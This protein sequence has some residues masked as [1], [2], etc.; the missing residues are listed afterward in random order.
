MQRRVVFAALFLLASMGHTLLTAGECAPLP[1]WRLKPVRVTGAF[2]GRATWM[3]HSSAGGTMVRLLDAGGILVSTVQSDSR[4]RFSF[5]R[6]PN[7]PYRV[8]IS[9][10]GSF[11]DAIEINN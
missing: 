7:G 10:G 3:G 5:G 8:D 11:F 2:C 9:D 6:V 1:E 4:G